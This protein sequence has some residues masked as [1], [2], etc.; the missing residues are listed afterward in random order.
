M[1]DAESF[2]SEIREAA[3][4]FAAALN[5]RYLVVA[6]G[7]GVKPPGFVED[8]GFKCVAGILVFCIAYRSN[9]K[10]WRGQRRANVGHS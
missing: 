6:C 10:L 7:G 8:G 1:G 9:L 4:G 2:V 3:D 5:F